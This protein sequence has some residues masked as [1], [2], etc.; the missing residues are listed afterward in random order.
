M[1]P[2]GSSE[3]VKVQSW[4]EA[5]LTRLHTSHRQTAVLLRTFKI[6]GHSRS[7]GKPGLS[8]E[9]QA[10]QLPWVLPC[11][12]CFAVMETG[13]RQHEASCGC[14]GTL[15][16]LGTLGPGHLHQPGLHPDTTLRGEGVVGSA[17]SA[18]W[19][20]GDGNEPS[21]QR[22]TSGRGRQRAVTA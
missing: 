22:T 21:P 17:P 19:M 8:Q 16:P 12:H 3:R 2:Q 4:S 18:P 10:W 5:T 13:P 20:A 1:A 14:S 11:K 6:L 9:T 15:G 7:C